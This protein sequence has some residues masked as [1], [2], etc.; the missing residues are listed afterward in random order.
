VLN[1][2]EDAFCDSEYSPST[3]CDAGWMKEIRLLI[4]ELRKEYGIKK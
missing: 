1:R 4:K 3:R 2:F